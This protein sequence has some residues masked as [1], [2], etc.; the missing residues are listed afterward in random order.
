M[1]R[2]DEGGREGGRERETER[3]KGREE[4]GSSE[5]ILE[6]VRTWWDGKSV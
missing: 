2:S 5:K 4:E 1:M 3:E 6:G